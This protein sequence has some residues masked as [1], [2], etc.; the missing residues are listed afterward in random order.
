MNRRSLAIA[1]ALTVLLIPAVVYATPGSFSSTNSTPAVTAVNTGSGV[2][3][4]ATSSTGIT[5]DFRRTSSSGTAAT[6]SAANASGATG[7]KAVYGNASA[8][9]T[10]GTFGV[11]GRAVASHGIGV[12]GTGPLY[13]LYSA[14]NMFVGGQVVCAGCIGATDVNRELRFHPVS[15]ANGA[16]LFASGS[17]TSAT[18]GADGLGLI[19]SSGVAFN[20]THCSN[21]ACTVATAHAIDPLLADST[22]IAIGSDGLGVVAY[23][24]STNLDLRV[25]HCS[26]VACTASTTAAVDTAGD[27]GSYASIAIGPDGFG[28]ISYSDQTNSTAKVAHCS[29]V[30]CT[31]STAT[32]IDNVT[33]GSVGQSS[34]I[35]GA[36]GLGLVSYYDGLNQDLKVAHCSNVACTS[37]STTTIDSAGDVG[38]ANSMVE[39]ADGLGLISYLDWGA[40]YDLKVAH[41]SDIA[42]S[43]ATP[44]TVDS[45]G[46]VGDTTSITIGAD[47][48]G[49]VSYQDDTNGDLKIAHCVNVAC[50]SVSALTVDAPGVVGEFSGITIGSDGLPL[51]SYE[52]ISADLKI[53]HCANALCVPYLRRR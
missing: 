39:G 32:V 47:G 26:N 46:Q 30:G 9:G 29:N 17:V 13:G 10:G 36:D 16:T 44:V 15:G 37:S 42:C 1:V 38:L 45:V 7:A 48:L 50:T 35:I 21:I 23:Y 4:L 22:S 34:M 11:Y 12:Y 2:G 51:V 6:L 41:C 28:L 52:G 25:A 19:S 3:V 33:P 53:M 43:V 8:L 24:E 49:I 40:N 5:G 31:S 14:T 27:V 20:V 18:I